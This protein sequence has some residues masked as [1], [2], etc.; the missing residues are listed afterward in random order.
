MRLIALLAILLALFIT[1]PGHGHVVD[2][3]HVH[4]QGEGPGEGDP[5]AHDGVAGKLCF[6]CHHGCGHVHAASPVPAQRMVMPVV[7]MPARYLLVE[8]P[9][10][11]TA[12]LSPP[13]KPPRA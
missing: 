9:P 1:P 12:D 5:A 6:D 8:T 13:Y 7:W 11:A 4:A 2:A 3:G 10:P